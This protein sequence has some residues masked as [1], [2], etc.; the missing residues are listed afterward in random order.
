[1]FG[2][3]EKFGIEFRSALMNE[4]SLLNFTKV[5]V[6]ILEDFFTGKP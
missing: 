1:M 4:T 3:A 5:P 2:P 6:S